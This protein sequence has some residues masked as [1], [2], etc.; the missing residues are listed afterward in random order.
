MTPGEEERWS[1]VNVTHPSGITLIDD[2]PEFKALS[3]PGVHIS[4]CVL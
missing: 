3:K 1:L 2:R 4:A